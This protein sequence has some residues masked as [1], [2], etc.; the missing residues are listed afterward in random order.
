MRRNLIGALAI[1]A[2]CSVPLTASAQGPAAP[3]PRDTARAA[4]HAEM[5]ELDQRLEAK[6]GEVE[7]NRGDA[8]VAALTEVVR[9]LVAQRRVMH[10]RMA[11]HSGAGMPCPAHG[12]HPKPGPCPM[13]PKAPGT[14]T[15]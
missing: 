14:G 9:E 7:R 4:M 5:A 3:C 8:K 13:H 11:R 1:A 6:L 15:E 2:L 10:E 12:A